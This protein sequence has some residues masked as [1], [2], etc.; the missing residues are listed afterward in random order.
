MYTLEEGEPFIWNVH[1]QM[2]PSAQATSHVHAPTFRR[3][4]RYIGNLL[5]S[6]HNPCIILSTNYCRSLVNHNIDTVSLA[7]S[8]LRS[9]PQDDSIQRILNIA[10]N[11]WNHMHWFATPFVFQDHLKV[12]PNLHCYVV[13]H[14][15]HISSFLYSVYVHAQT[16]FRVWYNYTKN[17]H[18]FKT[19][20]ETFL[21]WIHFARTCGNLS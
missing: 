9:L 7:N 2:K 18:M 15:A 3:T 16:S 21:V 20:F 14:H 6:T 5:T 19:C 10:W 13:D 11:I 4:N 12:R 8:Q 1:F 17:F